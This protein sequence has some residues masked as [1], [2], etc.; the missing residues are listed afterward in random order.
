[1]TKFYIVLM[2]ILTIVAVWCSFY[3]T[4]LAKPG[5]AAKGGSVRNGSYRRGRTHGYMH[6][7]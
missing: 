6:G 1:M 4:L 7:K 2:T 3:G 5:N